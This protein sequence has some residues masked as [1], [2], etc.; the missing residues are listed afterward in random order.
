MVRS[1]R[2]ALFFYA[3]ACS[4][5]SFLTILTLTPFALQDKLEPRQLLNRCHRLVVVSRLRDATALYRET[6]MSL[7]LIPAASLVS[8]F[9]R[10]VDATPGARVPLSA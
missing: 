4:S 2:K 9:A 8:A 1:L 7:S 10:R 3:V 6:W 5:A